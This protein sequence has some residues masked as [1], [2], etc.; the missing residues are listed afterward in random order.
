MAWIKNPFSPAEPRAPTA[1]DAADQYDPSRPFDADGGPNREE[2]GNVHLA[3]KFQRQTEKVEASEERAVGA[4]VGGDPY[5]DGVRAD[6]DEQHAH[7]HK[8]GGRLRVPG[9]TG[10]SQRF[11]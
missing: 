3:T 4:T 8:V 9:L 10:R 11:S 1:G 7:G 5:G 2:L 6:G